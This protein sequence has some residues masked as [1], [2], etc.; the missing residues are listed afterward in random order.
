M[1]AI[2][3]RFKSQS[4]AATQVTVKK[5]C[6]SECYCPI[7]FHA[8]NPFFAVGAGYVGMYGA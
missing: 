2:S 6:C 4:L 7:T 3:Q 1:D 5:I 8:L